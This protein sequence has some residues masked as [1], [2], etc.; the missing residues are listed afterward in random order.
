[1]GWKSLLLIWLWMLTVFT[2]VWSVHSITGNCTFLSLY[3]CSLRLLLYRYL[4]PRLA[5][6]S[7]C[8]V[9]NKHTEVPGCCLVD[10]ILS[11]KSQPT[12]SQL[13]CDHCFCS[14]TTSTPWSSQIISTRDMAE[15]ILNNSR[16]KEEIKTNYIFLDFIKCQATL[17]WQIRALCSMYL[18]TLGE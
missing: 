3:D 10:A 9:H 2:K 7:S 13:F 5:S 6:P 12:W 15:I 1:M 18:R 4:I 11:E 8:A 17:Y 14:F 16:I